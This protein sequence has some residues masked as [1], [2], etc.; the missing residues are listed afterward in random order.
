MAGGDDELI[1]TRTGDIS[2]STGI[3]IGQNIRQVI[4]QFNLSKDELADLL[5]RRVARGD[6]LD[7]KSSQFLWGQFVAERTRDFVGREHVFDAIEDFLASEPNGYFVIKGDP[8]F[9]KSSILA[10]Y[11]LRTNCIAHFNVAAQ[12]ITSAG[13]FLESVCSQLIVALDLPY[14]TLPST[15]TQDGAFLMR[16][17][18][19]AAAKS[20]APIVIAIDALDEVNVSTQSPRSN[21]LYLPDIVPDGVF[22]VMT[23]R[24]P[25]LRLPNAR[26]REFKLADHPAENRADVAAYLRAAFERPAL[27]RW[28]RRQRLDGGEDVVTRLTTLSEGNFMYL[29]HVLPAIEGGEYQGLDIDKLP[30]GLEAYYEDHWEA[31]GMANGARSRTRLRIVYVLCEARA[32]IPGWVIAELATD[33][34][35]SVDELDVEGVLED[36]EQFLHPEGGPENPRYSIYHSSFRDFLHRKRIVG[37]ALRIEDIHRR[38]ADCLSHELD[39]VL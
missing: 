23:Q 36:W 7:V 22:F 15:A 5:D 28:S 18:G 1:G 3:A 4:N 16:I 38:I 9:G 25:K 19:E 14:A 26:V 29:R 12:G 30:D 6:R 34:K 2:N 33:D 27:R 32:P 20:P 39:L 17:L 8:G 13:R 37:R 21:I 24:N 31:M 11:V 10:E 35:C